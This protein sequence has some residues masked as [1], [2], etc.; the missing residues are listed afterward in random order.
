M[1]QKRRESDCWKEG[2]KKKKD[3][4]KREIEDVKV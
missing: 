3:L 1:S 2:K 4:R